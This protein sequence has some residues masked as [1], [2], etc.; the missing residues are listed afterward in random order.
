LSRSRVRY[1]WLLLTAPAFLF[2]LVTSAIGPQTEPAFAD[3]YTV[4]EADNSLSNNVCDAVCTLGDAIVEANNHANSLNSGSVP[5]EITIPDLGED[6]VLSD[7]LPAITESVIITGP[8]AAQQTIDA[9]TTPDCCR[10]I[11]TI[12]PDIDVTISGLTLTG[13]VDDFGGAVYVS[14]DATAHLESVAITGNAAVTT[15]GGGQGGGIFV[16]AGGQLE[17]SETTITNNTADGAGGGIYLSDNA[18]LAMFGG[19]ITLNSSQ[20]EG[21]GIYANGAGEAGTSTVTITAADISQNFARFE[22]GGI[23]VSSDTLLNLMPGVTII[24]NTAGT[25]GDEGLGILPASGAGGGIFAEFATVT[26]DEVT[27]AGNEALWTTESVGQGGGIWLFSATLQLTDSTIGGT[28]EGEGNSSGDGGGIH[29][30]SG[31]GTVTLIRSAVIGNE[32]LAVGGGLYVSEYV[33]NITNSTISG[34]TAGSDGAAIYLRGTPSGTANL[35][36]TTVANNVVGDGNGGAAISADVGGQLWLT[37]SLLANNLADS[38]SL[39]TGALTLTGDN[40]VDGTCSDGLTFTPSNT[41][42]ADLD[43]LALNGGLTLNHALQESNAAVNGVT[44]TEGQTACAALDPPEDQRGVERPQGAACDI[45]AFELQSTPPDLT[46][47]KFDGSGEGGIHIDQP[48]PWLIDVENTGGSPAV[49]LSGDTV[50]VDELPGGGAD[51]PTY[52]P[53]SVSVTPFNEGATGVECSLTDLLLECVAGSEGAT[54]PAGG[55]FQVGVDVTPHAAGSLTNPPDGGICM[56]DPPQTEVGVIEESDETNNFCSDTVTIRM[57]DLAVDKWTFLETPSEGPSQANLG[58]PFLWNID[59]TNVGTDEASFNGTITSPVTILHDDLPAGFTYDPSSLQVTFPNDGQGLEN[60]ECSID[61]NV[62]T[63]QAIGYVGVVD[64]TDCGFYCPPSLIRVSFLATPITPGV[65]TNPPEGG[66]C[67]V[68]P[69]D[70]VLE[71]DEANNACSD[72]VDVLAADLAVALTNDVGGN[73]TI[74]DTFT[75]TVTITNDG[76]ADA[77]FDEGA[78]LFHDDLPSGPTYGTPN[79]QVSDGVDGSSAISCTLEDAQITCEIVGVES[80]VTIPPGESITITFSVTPNSIG[81]LTNPAGDGSCG[82]STTSNEADQD[83]NFC[84]DTVTVSEEATVTPTPSET[85]TETPTG[86]VEP[87]NTPTPPVSAPG[88]EDDSTSTATPT[89]SPSATATGTLTATP[90]TTGTPSPVPTQTPTPIPG[91]TFTPIPLV[92]NTGGTQAP[93][94]GGTE[95]AGAGEVGTS[96]PGETSTSVPGETAT[97]NPT[98]STTG[99][100]LPGTTPPITGNQTPSPSTTPSG[101]PGNEVS[102]TGAERSEWVESLRGLSDTSGDIDVLLTNLILTGVMLILIFLTSEVF[103]QT[104]S[105]NQDDIESWFKD[106]FGPIVAVWE[107]IQGPMHAATANHQQVLNLFWIA[108]VLIV[109]VFIQGFLNPGFPFSHGSVML[110]LSLLVGVGLMTYLTEGAE[111]FMARKVWREN[112]AVRVFPFAILI[113]AVCVFFSRLG[114]VVPGVMYGFVGTAVF[115]SPSS[116]NQDQDGKN[117]FVPKVLLLALCVVAWLLVDQFRGPNPSSFDVFMEGVLVGVFVGGLEGTF[118][119]IVPIAYLDGHKIMKWNPLAW[120]SLAVVATFLFWLVLL[121][122]Q[123]TYYN[124]IQETSVAAALIAGGSCLVLSCLTW[125]WFRYR[126]GGH[127]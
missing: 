58:D 20:D 78:V 107:G 43:P 35:V 53:D 71:P 1:G 99:T 68:D 12:S 56:V 123:R 79:V 48:F 50:L 97:A 49:F 90:T 39:G 23:Y 38:C 70:V 125:A 60:I 34:N 106:K 115:L 105:D 110:F 126:P 2:V 77:S 94:L 27:I 116:M 100:P 42:A 86:T 18:G 75:W 29:T 82:V 7:G 69:D 127:D 14:G 54:I 15:E 93:G 88:Q 32:A 120:V 118:I 67:E 101:T 74:G 80:S 73:V 30:D 109:S 113:A 13:G 16:A 87:T 119:N 98:A 22:G 57:A 114:G 17:L 91:A 121:N 117:V 8:G 19:S 52:D 55:G 31:P 4:N 65:S 96:A 26:G 76:T 61:G 63:C 28:G 37:N 102:S 111:A 3:T 46:A 25:E 24:G 36:H 92:P 112:A 40:L 62:L 104:L 103:N 108:L 84:S 64:Y 6:I 85:P 33:A 47:D 81:V 95:M 51:G 5:D 9:N 59:I 21:G 44:S 45:G 41:T 124:S 11:F 122:D 66:T 83:D 72:T 10:R 89:G